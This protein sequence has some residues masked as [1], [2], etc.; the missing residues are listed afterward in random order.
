MPFARSL[1]VYRREAQKT[2]LA[3]PLTALLRMMNLAP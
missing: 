1:P 3:D 2:T